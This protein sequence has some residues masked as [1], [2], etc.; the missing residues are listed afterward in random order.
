MDAGATAVDTVRTAVVCLGLQRVSYLLVSGVT[1]VVAVANRAPAAPVYCLL[2]VGQAGWTATL[3]TLA[4]R[5]RRFSATA[6]WADVG[7]AIGAELFLARV[8]PADPVLSTMDYRTQMDMA[9]ATLVGVALPRYPCLL[10]M[11]VLP[12]GLLASVHWTAGG[13]SVEWTWVLYRINSYIWWAAVAWALG[14]FLHVQRSRAERA[15]ARLVVVE[16]ERARVAER[17]AQ[18]QRLHDTVLATLTAIA[19]GGLDHRT[20]EVRQRCAREAEYLR[21]LV[22]YE[23][24]PHT[25]LGGALSRVI[26]DAQAL[27]LQVRSAGHQA[28]VDLPAEVVRALAEATREALNNV[29]RHSGRSDAWVTVTQEGGTTSIRVVDRGRGMSPGAHSGQGVRESIVG[30][31]RAAGG[32]ARIDTVPAEGTSVELSWPAS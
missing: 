28:A 24:D 22:R 4:W 18:R 6:T 5:R 19:R 23:D 20:D 25:G 11:A 27:G 17:W 10:A 15:T 12:A 2:V 8:G 31:M 7:F 16:A 9:A 1:A 29:L 3:L 21:H 30:R 32:R 26:E 14:E 13:P